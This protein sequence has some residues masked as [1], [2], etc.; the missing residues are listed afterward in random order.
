M[1]KVYN[2][3]RTICDILKNRNNMDPSLL[4]TAIRNYLT[5]KGK[6]IP[7]L[8]DYSKK[9]RIKTILRRYLEISL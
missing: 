1:I 3:E 8:L 7:K 4:N 6:N 5:S 2:K 9:L